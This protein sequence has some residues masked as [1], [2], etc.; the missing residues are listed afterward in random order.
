MQ[1]ALVVDQQADGCRLGSVM[2]S[3]EDVDRHNPGPRR[4]NSNPLWCDATVFGRLL[5]LFV[6]VPLVELYLLLSVA[7]VTGVFSTVALVIVTGVIGSYLARREGA[8]VLRRVRESM[9][10]GR[11]PAG[12]MQDGLMIVFAAA[13][14]LTPGILTDAIG[15][16]LLTAA[17][18]A[19]F[20]KQIASRF[21]AGSSVQVRTFGSFESTGSA[22]RGASSGAKVRRDDGNTIDAA[23]VRRVES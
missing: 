20:R 7:S 19:F 22:G 4:P 11:M 6:T 15:F 8:G 14:L 10:A 17:G 9:A 2:L 21:F 5:L 16:L 1:G 23:A 18:R 12:E 13:L 3:S